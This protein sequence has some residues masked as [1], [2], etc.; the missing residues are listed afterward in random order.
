MYQFHS[1]GFTTSFIETDSGNYL[2]VTLKNKII[3]NETV[4]DYINKY[5]YSNKAEQNSIREELI[6]RSF[7]VSYMKKN[8]KIN[9]I[10]FD[11]SPKTQTF[12]YNGK[13]TILFLLTFSPYIFL[14]LEIYF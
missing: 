7:K 13:N 10:I 14:F 2:I 1:L 11:R 9:D 5:D 3:Q 6:G 12:N 4:L 8:H